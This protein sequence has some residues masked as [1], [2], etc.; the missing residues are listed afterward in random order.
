MSLR[1][2]WAFLTRLPG[3]AHPSTERDLDRIVPWF[4]LVGAIVGTLSDGVFWALWQPLG[5]PLAAILAIAA[6]AVINW[7]ISRGRPG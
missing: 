2:A 6:G 4:P 1:Y 5:A 7:C 3:G